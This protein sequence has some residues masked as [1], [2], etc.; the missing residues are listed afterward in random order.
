MT[1]SPSLLEIA[2]IEERIA[3]KRSE[4]TET[5]SL[6]FRQAHR[7]RYLVEPRIEIIE[8]LVA[9]PKPHHYVTRKP[10]LLPQILR[11]LNVL[12]RP[13]IAKPMRSELSKK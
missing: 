8:A 1:G 5:T 10:N 11:D 9:T 2:Q 6:P 12:F 3:V 7:R 13:T 4:H